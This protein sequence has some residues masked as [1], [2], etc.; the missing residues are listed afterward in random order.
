MMLQELDSMLPLN[1]ETDSIKELF[2]KYNNN[3]QIFTIKDLTPDIKKFVIEMLSDQ[4][5]SGIY[6]IFFDDISPIENYLKAVSFSEEEVPT[7]LYHLLK[8]IFLNQLNKLFR[9]PDNNP[10]D[11]GDIENLLELL[12]QK[13]DEIIENSSNSSILNNLVNEPRISLLLE[14]YILGQTEKIPGDN[15]NLYL[16]NIANVIKFI[17]EFKITINLWECQNTFNDLRINPGFIET[18]DDVSLDLFRQ[19]ENLLGFTGGK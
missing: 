17:N 12:T 5:E 9:N 10:I 3:I 18:L 11:L 19:V 13:S 14:E 1:D 6:S 2:Q 7:Q 16:T 15:T 4:I 8:A